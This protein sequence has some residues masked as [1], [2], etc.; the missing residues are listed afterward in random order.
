[1][2]STNN[3]PE[4]GG[5]SVN[6]KLHGALEERRMMREADR[7][8]AELLV[9]CAGALRDGCLPTFLKSLT[10]REAHTMTGWRDFSATTQIVRALNSAAFA[11]RIAEPNLDLFISRVNAKIRC[12]SKSG[13]A[14]RPLGRIAQPKPSSGRQCSRSSPR[15]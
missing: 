13:A 4:K 12:R 5:R 7:Q 10:R 6:R 9:D 1:M 11:G 14:G 8:I 15:S 3:I 2:R